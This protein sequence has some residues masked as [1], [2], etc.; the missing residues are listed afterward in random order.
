MFDVSWSELLVVIIIA[1]FFIKPE[2]LPEI[3]RTIGKFFAKVKRMTSEFSE[4]I[5]E[6]SEIADSSQGNE[7]QANPIKLIEMEK[8]SD[9]E[10]HIDKEKKDKL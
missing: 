1:L 10:Y 3:F 6:I 4:T 7:K 2:D 8:D 9:E 5:K